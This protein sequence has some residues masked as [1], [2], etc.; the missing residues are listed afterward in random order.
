MGRVAMTI[1]EIRSREPL[2]CDIPK[3]KRAKLEDLCICQMRTI[4]DLPNEL[5]AVKNVAHR[6][7]NK[8]A[9]H[10]TSPVCP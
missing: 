10:D 1:I 6:L 2:P 3:M 5:M 7:A 4:I 8:V 9:Q